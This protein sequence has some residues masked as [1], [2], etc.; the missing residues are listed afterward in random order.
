MSVLNDDDLFVYQEAATGNTGSVA[1]SN[2]SALADDDLFVIYRPST[3][4]NYSV[5]SEDVG[6]GTPKEAPVITDITISQDEVNNN[7]FT[8]NSFTT[9]ITA[10][11]QPINVQ[12]KAEIT[13][14]LS[15]EAGTN[16][17]VENTQTPGGTNIPLELA[18]VENLDNGAFEVGD[19]VKANTQYT[20]QTSAISNVNQISGGGNGLIAANQQYA[21]IK[22]GNGVFLATSRVDRFARSSQGDSWSTFTVTDRDWN[23]AAAG[24]NQWVIVGQGGGS[25]RAARLNFGG[26]SISTH[27]M[28]N[29]GSGDRQWKS[30]VWT[31]SYYVACFYTGAGKRFARS[32]DGSSWSEAGPDFGG[33]LGFQD[34][35]YADGKICAVNRVGAPHYSTDHGNS[36]TQGSGGNWPGQI[37]RIRYGNG[38]WMAIG[39]YPWSCNYSDDGVNWTAVDTSNSEPEVAAQVEPWGVAYGNGVWVMIGGNKGAAA[40]SEDNG[41]TW[42]M[43]SGLAKDSYWID[44]A[45]GNGVFVTVNSS[46][47]APINYAYSYDGKLWGDKTILTLETQKDLQFFEPGDEIPGGNVVEVDIDAK[48][49]EVSGGN[50]VAGG[51]VSASNPKQGRGTISQISGPNVLIEPYTDNAFLPGQYLIHDTPKPIKVSPVSDSITSVAGDALLFSGGKDLLNFEAGDQ[52]Y[53]SDADGNVAQIAHPTSAIT[54]AVNGQATTYTHTGFNNFAFMEPYSTTNVKTTK[55][56]LGAGLTSTGQIYLDQ[57]RYIPG[58]WRFQFA[59]SRADTGTQK[60]LIRYQSGYVAYEFQDNGGENGIITAEIGPIKNEPILE[61]WFELTNP[62]SEGDCNFDFWDLQTSNGTEFVPFSA[63]NADVTLNFFDDTNLDL[64]SIGDT[65]S[66]GITCTLIGLDP[67]FMN[68]SGGNWSAGQTVNAYTSGTA[69][70][71]SVDPENTIL[72]MTNSNGEWESGYHAATA[73]KNA[74]AM[75]AYLSFDSNGNNVELERF[76]QPYTLMADLLQPKL[77]FPSTFD[78][79]EAP[80]TD[81]PSPSYIQTYAIAT[82]LIGSSVEVGSNLLFP[83]TLTRSIPEAGSFRYTTEEFGEFCRW[84]CSTDYRAAIKTIEGTTE[85]VNDL[86]QKAEQMAED[87]I[88]SVQ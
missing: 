69:E 84:A 39:A 86:R 82:N 37:N 13:G 76:A 77:T 29:F 16:V 59:S 53:M 36:W 67:P 52:I 9:N 17:I 85:T 75:T 50:W 30:V 6:G 12:L 51:I 73:E 66:P 24:P 27:T 83:E 22:F 8:S 49:M 42:K 10:T 79:G 35:W 60:V 80:D 2:R 5:K 81:I 40:Y 33:L 34:L 26:T 68:V 14:A 25:D 4:L 72:T 57:P 31:G 87:Y 48:T 61:I 20:P 74:V 3:G 88:N 32:S 56:G 55:D 1:N 41:V 58:L 65:V 63:S 71:A 46:D 44:L 28:P 15:I 11:N 78:T 38:R 62:S 43:A 18:G 70:V 7:R 54:S 64:F 19:V 45:F 47:S 23:G 21:N